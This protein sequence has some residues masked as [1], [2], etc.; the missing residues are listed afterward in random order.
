MSRVE[1]RLR[2]LRAPDEPAAELRAWAIARSVYAEREPTP[3]RGRGRV[4]VVVAAA[5]LAGGALLALSPAGAAVRGW[6]DRAL[7]ARHAS[8]ALFSL[9][10][11]GRLLVAG[12]EGAWAISADGSRRRLGSWSQASWS[13]HGLYIGVAARNKLGAVDGRGTPQW[14]IARPE[15]RFPR[16]FSPTGYRLAYLSGT[17]LRV[18]AGDGSGD[19]LLAS[20]V[21]AVAPAWRPDHPYQLAYATARGTVIVRDADTGQIVW[22][23][24]LAV[25]P[26]RLAWSSDGARLLVLSRDAALL[27]NANGRFDGRIADGEAPLDAALSPD[28]RTL[29]LLGDRTV[30]VTALSSPGQRPRRVFTGSGLGQLAWSPDARWLLVSWPTA[31]QWIFVH[32]RGRPRIAAISRI[33]EQFGS[34]GHGFPQLDGW[35]CS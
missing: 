20:G 3:A 6:L 7:G 25:P 33:A 5:V 35:C 14:T 12:S 24:S 27:F 16:W 4:R 30:T 28:G 18:I 13:P 8:S 34:A 21:A 10:S 23:Q 17:T 29:A 1:Q 11:S 9:P 22:R 15:V 2:G 26:R 31:D 19:R 32:T